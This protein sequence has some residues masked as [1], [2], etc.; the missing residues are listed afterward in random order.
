MIDPKYV[1]IYHIHGVVEFAKAYKYITEYATTDETEIA[2][3]ETKLHNFEIAV[4]CTGLHHM[5][6]AEYLDNIGTEWN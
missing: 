4:Y 5:R 3:R 1:D 6:I 2:V